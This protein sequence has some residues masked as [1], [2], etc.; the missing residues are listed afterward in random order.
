MAAVAR[1][2]SSAL[3]LCNLIA[4]FCHD[5][6]SNLV[7]ARVSNYFTVHRTAQQDTLRDARRWS[8]LKKLKTSI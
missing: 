1:L 8:H 7:A 5:C 4:S 3:L 2:F 6:I